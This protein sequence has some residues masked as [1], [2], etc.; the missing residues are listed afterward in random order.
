MILKYCSSIFLLYNIIFWYHKFCGNYFCT[1]YFCTW[2]L[3]LFKCTY[4][5]ITYAE[6][7]KE[8]RTVYERCKN[9]KNIINIHNVGREFHSVLY[10]L[11]F[12]F[13]VYAYIILTYTSLYREFISIY[14]ISV[15]Q[16]KDKWKV[17]TSH[18]NV[19]IV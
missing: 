7:P 19:Q 9:Y 1:Y 6:S 14:N 13:N 5:D 12:I 3:F 11:Y 4:L 2:A 18:Q 16:Y 15:S 10:F 17:L 8:N